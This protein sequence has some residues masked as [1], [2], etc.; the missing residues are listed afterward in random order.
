MAEG[1]YIRLQETYVHDLERLEQ[2]DRERLQR[3][4]AVQA[5]YRAV[6]AQRQKWWRNWL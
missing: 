2:E 3:K 1:Q 4:K 6:Y 5:L